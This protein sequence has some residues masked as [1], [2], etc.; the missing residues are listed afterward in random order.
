MNVLKL[1]IA[2]WVAVLVYS[3]ASLAVGP[4]GGLAMHSLSSEQDRLLHNMEQLR[5]INGSLEGSLDALQYD[6]DTLA[7]Y[8]RELGYGSKDEQFVRIVGVPSTGRKKIMAGNIVAVDIPESVRS[9]TL[10]IISTL[11]GAIALLIMILK[12]RKHGRKS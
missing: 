3:A 4:T 8:A 9:S 7:V 11:A 2:F 5:G 1:L 12:T 10:R 6:R